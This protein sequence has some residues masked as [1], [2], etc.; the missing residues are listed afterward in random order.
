MASLVNDA[1]AASDVLGR[2]ALAL[3]NSVRLAPDFPSRVA[4]VER[5]VAMMLEKREPDAAI[6]RA[7]RVLMAVQGRARIGNLVRKVGPER[8]PVSASLCDRSRN[9]AKTVCANDP[10]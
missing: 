1:A 9:D 3:D 4:A 10:V 2:S 8:Q 6:E 5:W 7:S